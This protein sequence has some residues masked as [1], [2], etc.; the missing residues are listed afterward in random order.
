[1]LKISVITVCFNSAGTIKDTIE[2]IS[3]QDYPK[4]EHIVVDGGSTDG[5]IDILRGSRWVSSWIS[6]PDF[7][8]YDAMNKGLRLATGDVVGFLNADDVYATPTALSQI[9]QAFSNPEVDACY[10]DLV[11]VT[12]DDI[13]RV[14]RYWKSGEYTKG[15]F[16]KGWM[17]PHPTFYARHEVYERFGGFDLNFKIAADVEFLMH[18]IEAGGIRLKYIPKL[19][20]RMRLGG[21]TNRSL[22]NILKQNL[23]VARAAKKNNIPF[24]MIKYALCKSANRLTQFV[25][26]PPE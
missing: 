23:E 3:Q 10:G 1:M 26:K 24:F 2:S 12:Q 11:Y 9:A 25:R 8:I 7:G 4:V 17:P 20:V 14:V 5:T 15:N 13:S 22:S 16:S 18:V 19:L 6:E 21:V